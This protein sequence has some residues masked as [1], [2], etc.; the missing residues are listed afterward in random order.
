MEKRLLYSWFVFCCKH[1]YLLYVTVTVIIYYT[2]LFFIHFVF[3]FYKMSKSPI[4]N[5]KIDNTDNAKNN[6][7]NNILTCIL[8]RNKIDLFETKHTCIYVRR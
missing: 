3:L 7:N 1:S 8:C 4:K 6:D 2:L 5:K